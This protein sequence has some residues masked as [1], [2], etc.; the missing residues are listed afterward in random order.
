VVPQLEPWYCWKGTW[1]LVGD[2]GPKGGVDPNHSRQLLQ[3]RAYMTSGLHVTS[4]SPPL[5]PVTSTPL[6][7]IYIHDVHL[8]ASCLPIGCPPPR[9]PIHNQ[10]IIEK[11]RRRVSYRRDGVCL[12]SESSDTYRQ[13]VKPQ[14]QVDADW[15]QNTSADYL[16]LKQRSAH[17]TGCLQWPPT[18]H[19]HANAQCRALFCHPVAYFLP[20]QFLQHMHQ[21][22]LRDS[23]SF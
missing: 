23:S 21:F 9:L 17:A 12:A 18:A 13:R 6:H 1:Q 5:T 8:H 15:F 16:F 7:F 4:I 22:C 2:Y 10:F 19:R 14:S 3:S 20:I 11:A